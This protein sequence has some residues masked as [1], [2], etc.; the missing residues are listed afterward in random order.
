MKTVTF[1]RHAKSS[2]EKNLPDRDRP[3]KGRGVKDAMLVANYFKGLGSYF[4]KIQ[5]MRK[6]SSLISDD[7]LISKDKI[8]IASSICKVDLMS[9]LVGEFPELQGIV[10]G[11]FAKF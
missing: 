11:H 4:D 9:D 6:L 2:W 7:F 10:G 5:R 8:E 1:I 3:L